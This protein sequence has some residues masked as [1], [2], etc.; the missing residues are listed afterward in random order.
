MKIEEVKRE[1][2]KV[3]FE[4]LK[5]GDCYLDSNNRL[6]MKMDSISSDSY[7]SYDCICLEDGCIGSDW[8]EVTLVE[9]TIQYCI[10]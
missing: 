9:A 2:K 4:N 5:V 8:G 7:D 10:K 1:T 3:N 6:C